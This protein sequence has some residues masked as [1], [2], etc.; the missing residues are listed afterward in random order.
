MEPKITSFNIYVLPKSLNDISKH[1]VTGTSRI[2]N[3]AI[4]E[5]FSLNS[6]RLI[7]RYHDWIGGGDMRSI[8]KFKISNS[9]RK[10]KNH[11]KKQKSAISSFKYRFLRIK[12]TIHSVT[13]NGEDTINV[14]L[15]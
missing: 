5:T 1:K 15:Q 4:K 11:S 2:H 7:K 8:S 12:D 9:Y 13:D 10:L 6:M 14:K 3:Y